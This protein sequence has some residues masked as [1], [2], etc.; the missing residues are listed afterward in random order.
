MRKNGPSSM[1]PVSKPTS[2][3]VGLP[4]TIV[5][6]PATDEI[7]TLM[8]VGGPFHQARQHFMRRHLGAAGVQPWGT[9]LQASSR[10]AAQARQWGI[11]ADA[12]LDQMRAWSW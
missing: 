7:S 1:T 12:G 6:V 2:A 4:R 9:Q 10:Q 5:A 3:Q 11:L 8:R